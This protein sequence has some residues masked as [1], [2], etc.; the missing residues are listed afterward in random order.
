MTEHKFHRLDLLI[1]FVVKI[2]YLYSLTALIPFG[3]LFFTSGVRAIPQ[4]IQ[5]SPLIA[6]GIFAVSLILL[7]AHYRD[8]A[9]SLASLG[10][11][12]LLVGIT[13]VLFHLLH[14]Q[15]VLGLFQNV[16][17]GFDKIEPIIVK[18]LDDVFPTIWLFIIGY[19]VL[20]IVL[21][22]IAGKMEPE[23]SMMSTIRKLFKPR[24]RR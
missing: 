14:P 2:L 7:F 1:W 6:L 9:H 15:S 16:V 3:A 19:I 11:M 22:Y 5:H 13:A 24:K 17:Y 20:G 23:H 10:W 8:L 4:E 21:L 12:A 18:E